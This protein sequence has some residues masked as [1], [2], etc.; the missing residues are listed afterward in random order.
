MPSA[1]KAYAERRG[2]GVGR[3]QM[4][5]E[6]SAE[7]V[8]VVVLR[9]RKLELPARLQRYR[10]AAALVEKADQL[11]VVLDRAPIRGARAS[12]PAARRCPLALVGDRRQIGE[13]ERDLLVLGADL[14]SARRLAAGLEPRDEVAPTVHRLRIRHI[15][16]HAISRPPPQPAA[17]PR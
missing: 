4:R 10:A 13:V 3:L 12:P 15:A 16:R 9:A 7:R 8:N 11:A 2:G 5:R 6:F 1:A 17:R 14:E